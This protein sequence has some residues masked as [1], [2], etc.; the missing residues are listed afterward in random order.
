MGR[1]LRCGLL[2]ALLTLSFG[3]GSAFES[4]AQQPPDLFRLFNGVIQGVAAQATQAEWRKLLQNEIGCIDNKLRSNRSSVAQLIQSGIQP[5]DPTLSA[6]RN[7]CRSEL[8]QE[9]ANPNP[10]PQRAMHSTFTAAGIRPGDT[11]VPQASNSVRLFFARAERSRQ[12]KMGDSRA[13][14]P[15]YILKMER[16]SM[17]RKI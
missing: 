10:S 15:C 1:G 2:A 8:R 5:S 12:I 11:N 14:V 9:G 7:E 3:V 4:R 17:S 13:A 16:Q 6:V